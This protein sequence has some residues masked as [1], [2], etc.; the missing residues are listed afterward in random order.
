MFV[1]DAN[2]TTFATTVAA[3]GANNVPVVCNGTNWI[4]GANDNAPMSKVG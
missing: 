1:T 3:G 2:A 4:I